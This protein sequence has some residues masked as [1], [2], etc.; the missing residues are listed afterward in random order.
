MGFQEG[1]ATVR[2]YLV[3][4]ELSEDLP[5]TATVSLRRES[6]RP[7]DDRK[8]EKQS[9]G[10]VNPRA[11][12]QREIS[13][14]EVVVSNGLVFLGYR[15]DKKSFSPVLFKARMKEKIQVV[16]KE[17]K[18]EKI[19]KAQRLALK[20]ELTVE[21]LSETSPRSSF[22]ELIW[23]MNSNIVLMSSTSNTLCDQIS[24]AF[25]KSFN[26]RLRPLFPSVTG[27]EFIASQGLEKEFA[28]STGAQGG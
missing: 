20:D 25:T 3:M 28:L 6:W 19:S 17:K 22:S 14:E 24:E 21:M 16:K 13:W 7:I 12:L 18:V 1:N 26:P 15:V 8:G 11:L 27:A 5:L 4:G 23:D 9:F 2:R 10:W